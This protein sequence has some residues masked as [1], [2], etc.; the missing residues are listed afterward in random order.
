VNGN[1]VAFDGMLQALKNKNIWLVSFNVFTVY[2]VYCGIT[3]FIPFLKEIY[4]F[5]VVLV[6]AYGIIN[7]YGLKMFAGPIAG[8]ISDKVLHSP[9]KLIRIVFV[10]TAVALVGFT[11]L[12]HD[13]INVYIGMAITLSISAC[14]FCMRAVF[15]APM[16][17]VN[18]PLEITGSAMSLGS[19]IGYLPGAFM[20]TVYGN[21][22]DRNPGMAG[23]RIVF[24]IMA[25]FAV[26]GFLLSSYILKT[27]KNDKKN[28]TTTS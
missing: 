26:I 2:C 1:K 8:F 7:Q 25:I 18:V 20:F 16:S 15:F 14:I 21:I 28:S 4:A 22:L 3:Y 11:F 24:I 23:Y 6:G 27:I 13:R 12:P 19:F 9:T 10:I 5:P 17:E